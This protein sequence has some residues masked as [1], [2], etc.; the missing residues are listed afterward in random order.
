MLTLKLIAQSD[1]AY[2]STYNYISLLQTNVMNQK[3]ILPGRERLHSKRVSH[4]EPKAG[5]V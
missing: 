1:T 5:K 2:I 3:G 4:V